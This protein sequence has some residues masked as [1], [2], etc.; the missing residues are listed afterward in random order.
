M[1]LSHC[2]R[3]AAFIAVFSLWST[4]GVS[5]AVTC[6]QLP[7]LVTVNVAG[8]PETLTAGSDL[9]IESNAKA[10]TE[11]L[12]EIYDNSELD[13]DLLEELNKVDFSN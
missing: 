11:V 12:E 7:E 3:Q 10:N 2:I 13:D 4:R 6:D 5:A 8:V 9:N 1:N